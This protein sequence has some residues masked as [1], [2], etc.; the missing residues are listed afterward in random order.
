MMIVATVAAG[1][2]FGLL[3]KVQKATKTGVYIIKSHGSRLH[4]IGF[5]C[6]WDIGEQN[7][8]F[9]IAVRSNSFFYRT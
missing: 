6:L 5:L 2:L 3:D 8:S 1:A 4:Q 9:T 7:N